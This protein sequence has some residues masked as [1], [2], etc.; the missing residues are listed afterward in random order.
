MSWVIRQLPSLVMLMAIGS[1]VKDLR[2]L[3][4]LCLGI[5]RICIFLHEKQNGPSKQLEPLRII[6]CGAEGQNRT[7]DTGVFSAGCYLFL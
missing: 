1:R 3:N 7:P 4:Q 6:L 2:G 5:N